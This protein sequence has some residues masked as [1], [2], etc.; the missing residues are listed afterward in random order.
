MKVKVIKNTRSRRDDPDF[1]PNPSRSEESFLTL[2]V[3]NIYRV[4][5]VSYD[6]FRIMDDFGEPVLYEKELFEVVDPVLP[7]DWIFFKDGSTSGCPSC[8]DSED[9][10][11]N[12]APGCLNYVEGF[13]G[14]YFEGNR[15]EQREARRIFRGYILKTVG[16]G[17]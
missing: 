6:S 12:C 9:G 16:A 5:G 13:W 4:Y 3:G 17:G 7:S 15:E 10:S 1:E 2:T 14:K 11:I 8:Y